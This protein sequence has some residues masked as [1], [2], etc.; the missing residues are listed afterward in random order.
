MKRAKLLNEC[1]ELIK[2]FNPAVTTIDAHC[3]DKLGDVSAKTADPDKV[4]MK[5]VFYGCVR[6]KKALKVF[7]LNFYHD[8]AGTTL[9]NDYTMYMVMAYLAI[10]RLSEVGFQEFKRFINVEEPSKMHV[11]L[12]YLWDP[13]NIAGPIKQE[14][15][16]I[17]D[18]E[19]IENG[20]IGQI[21]KYRP[22]VHQLCQDL[23]TKAFGIA[24]KKQAAE[25]AIG[26]IKDRKPATVP[27]GP[28]LTRPRPRKVPEP[29]KIEQTFQSYE[30][31]DAVHTN[32]LNR[33]DK[34]SKAR[35]R[36]NFEETNSKYGL[37]HEF[38]MHETRSNMEAVRAEVEASREAELQFDSFVAKPMPEY[39]EDG[40]NVRLNIASVLR[41][42]FLYK[43]KQEAEAKTIKA[44][45]EDLRDANE[46][47]RWQSEMKEKDVKTH[48]V[49]VERRRLEMV[50]SAKDAIEAARRQKRENKEVADRIKQEGEAMSN[51]AQA[52]E[53]LIMLMNQKLVTEVKEIRETAPAEAKR[54]LDAQRLKRRQDIDAE[55]AHRA[56]MKA[57]EDAKYEAEK[58]DRVRQ[59][60]ALERVLQKGETGGEK[61][62]PTTTM[63]QGLLE[64][65]SLVELQER[66]A[67]NRVQV[68]EKESCKRRD[69]LVKKQDRVNDL[70]TRVA[71]SG[72]IRSAAK[73][74]NLTAR[75]RRKEKEAAAKKKEMEDRNEGN[76]RLASKLEA[77]RRSQREEA[78]ALVAEEKR[79]AQQRMFLGAKKSMIEEQH[80]DEQLRGAEREAR[81]RQTRAKQAQAMYETTKAGETSMKNTVIKRTK[82]A[83]R[84]FQKEQSTALSTAK[85]ELA[86]KK[87]E[88]MEAKKSAFRDERQNK[89]TLK[90]G[91]IRRNPYAEEK[92]QSVKLAARTRAMRTTQMQGTGSMRR[93]YDDPGE[94]EDYGEW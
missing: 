3:D 62:D 57:E 54:R 39:P 9:R 12:S 36:K 46:F 22:D 68:A 25:D 32:T 14:W 1:I 84:N 41:E 85:H 11:F 91:L 35:R 56:A 30:V 71:N 51:Q 79:I 27:V 80:F 40:A 89:E 6:N 88:Q 16:T 60:Q 8:N 10:F 13:K 69:I 45:E 72:R 75:A 78:D 15:L 94:D 21:T 42:D 43:T 70:K 5:Q 63:S 18:A 92:T 19:Y 73:N 20:M 50:Q 82:M 23:H 66:L 47:Y 87:H 4:F 81:E 52:E 90:T 33:I 53:E 7:L 26:E 83:T 17:F 38:R 64:E 86:N 44:Y 74:A 67:M 55:K 48:K 65:M 31:P 29:Q 2:S 93:A 28:K 77:Q 59:I 24:A 61:Y 37:N 58:A 49:E 34:K 76:M